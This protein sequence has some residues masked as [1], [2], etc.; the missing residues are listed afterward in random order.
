MN[1]KVEIIAQLELAKNEFIQLSNNKSFCKIKIRIYI[2]NDN[3]K[4][5]SSIKFIISQISQKRNDIS[6]NYLK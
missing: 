6:K 2:M 4:N 5:K 1:R 3:H